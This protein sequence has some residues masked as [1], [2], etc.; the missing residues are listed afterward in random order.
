M[1]GKKKNRKSS[2]NGMVIQVMGAE[3]IIYEGKLEELP[4]K[5]AVILAKSD[6]FFNDPNPCFIHRGAVS[7]RL[8]A[9]MEE[10]MEQ[11]NWE[12]WNCYA[13]LETIVCVKIV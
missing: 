10:A 4:L 9:E 13:D 6:E 5:E 8:Y 7:V 3:K 12:V 1:F 2:G 11:E